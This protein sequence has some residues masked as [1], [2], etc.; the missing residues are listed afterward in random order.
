[1]VKKQDFNECPDYTKNKILYENQEI[2][3]PFELLRIGIC[4]RA[5]MSFYS[6]VNIPF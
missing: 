2:I 4:V 1:M 3:D 6:A 5:E